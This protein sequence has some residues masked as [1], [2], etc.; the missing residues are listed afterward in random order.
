LRVG[1]AAWH[2]VGAVLGQT[3]DM[4]GSLTDATSR[5]PVLAYAS[6]STAATVAAQAVLQPPTS[7]GNVSS[8]Q[9]PAKAPL[10]WKKQ[11]LP[12]DAPVFKD[13]IWLRTYKNNSRMKR[14]K[15][16]I[17]DL[18]AEGDGSY[19]GQKV[20]C[21][22]E[23]KRGIPPDIVVADEL[24]L[25]YIRVLSVRVVQQ[26]GAAGDHRACRCHTVALRPHQLYQH[27]FDLHYHRQA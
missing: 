17:V 13:K 11:K 7:R 22:A 6:T 20:T 18:H 15:V 12:A 16:S 10:A 8:I 23:N 2:V 3:R 19:S 21:T 4:P 9:Q 1:V 5:S 14:T 27:T 25:W 24:V 26:S